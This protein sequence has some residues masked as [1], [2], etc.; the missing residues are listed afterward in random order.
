M[1]RVLTSRGAVK[2]GQQSAVFP[3]DGSAALR[4]HREV[5]VSGQCVLGD[6]DAVPVV[7]QKLDGILEDQ[8]G[9]AA[10]AGVFGEACRV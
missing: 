7:V 8:R 1:A 9:R 10:A 5:A 6:G 2:V 3:L 4:A